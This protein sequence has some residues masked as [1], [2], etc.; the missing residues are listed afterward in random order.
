ME[1]R[2]TNRQTR[3]IA[4][5]FVT[6]D[7]TNPTI[8]GHFAVFDVETELWDGYFETIDKDAFNGALVDDIRALVNHDTTLVLGRNKA[9]T[10]GL[11]TDDIG[12]FG[13]IK[14]NAADTDAMNLWHRVRRRDVTQCSF[15]FDILEEENEFRNDGTVHVVIKKVKLYE[16]S[17]CTF[18][19]YP[20]TGVEARAKDFEKHKKQTL[21]VWK[22]KMKERL[23]DGIKK[24]D[25]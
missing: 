6:R 24:I 13:N 16:V 2:K 18:P 14:I 20:D 1:V 5:D 9:G 12:L 4:C 17:V 7:E 10:L 25:A 23:K 8:E 15:G 11:A 19:A 22:E 3:T 21:A